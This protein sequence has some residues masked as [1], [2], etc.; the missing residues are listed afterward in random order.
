[1][2][3][4]GRVGVRLRTQTDAHHSP[5]TSTR[6]TASPSNTLTSPSWLLCSQS[7]SSETVCSNRGLPQN[8]THQHSLT[9]HCTCVR[10]PSTNQPMTR[11]RCPSTNRLTT[12]IRRPSTT[13]R[14][15]S[16]WRLV[17]MSNQHHACEWLTSLHRTSIICVSCH[18]SRS[19][20]TTTT[21]LN[22]QTASQHFMAPPPPQPPPLLLLLLLLFQLLT[23]LLRQRTNPSHHHHHQQRPL[24]LSLP[25][26][27]A[28]PTLPQPQ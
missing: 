13:N 16:L 20:K 3:R 10:C 18:W 19:Q 25:R 1:M 24:P 11:I 28:L 23:A 2:R 12:R 27:T 9:Q 17:R 14:P 4:G 21:Q 22:P 6:S 7:R 26:N 15:I 8:W 5:T